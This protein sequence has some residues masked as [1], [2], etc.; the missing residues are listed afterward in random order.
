MHLP[1]IIKQLA[2]FCTPTD[3]REPGEKVNATTGKVVTPAPVPEMMDATQLAAAI[4]E[5]DGHDWSV[6][7]PPIG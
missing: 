7:L 1:A 6:A 5:P 4:A 2:L 3:G